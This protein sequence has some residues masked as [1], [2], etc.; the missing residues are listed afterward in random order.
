MEY[1]YNQR[2]CHDRALSG[3]LLVEVTS[4]F[5]ILVPAWMVSESDSFW[6]VSGDIISGKNLFVESR[7]I[8]VRVLQKDV[9]FETAEERAKEKASLLAAKDALEKELGG[10]KRK[11]T[12][13]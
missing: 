11:L 4:R 3:S 13:Q 7:S 9:R 5:G 12:K 1:G 10:I 2:A 8:G 6:L